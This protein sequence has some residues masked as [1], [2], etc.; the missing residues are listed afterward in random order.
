MTT[1]AW[2]KVPEVKLLK[3]KGG[4]SSSTT[5]LMGAYLTIVKDDLDGWYKVHA[6][7][8][9][10]YVRKTDTSQDNSFLKLFFIDVGQ[11]DA[12]LIETPTKRMLVDGG[13]YA[14]NTKNYLTKWKYKW[15]IDNGGQIRIDAIVVSHFD[16]DHFGGLTS[17]ISDDRFTIGSV[18]HNGIARFDKSSSKRDAKYDTHIGETDKTDTNP[19]KRLKTSFNDIEDAKRLLAEG[20][21]MSS[22]RKFLQAVV[23]ATDAGSGI[24]DVHL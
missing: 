23:K 20:G 22:F 11:G 4:K 21:L 7:G 10:G 8:K 18:Y 16:A 9:E 5:V 17:I 6:F 24:G 14:R 15:L 19:R 3:T 2:C 13:Q 1:H 12:C